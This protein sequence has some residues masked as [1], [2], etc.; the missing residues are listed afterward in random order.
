MNGMVRKEAQYM[1]AT[2][3][4]NSDKAEKLEI[5]DDSKELKNRNMLLTESGEKPSDDT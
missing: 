2:I 3:S 1:E 5:Q 4:G